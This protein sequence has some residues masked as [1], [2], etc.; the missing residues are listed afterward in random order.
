MKKGNFQAAR[1]RLF[2]HFS[3]ALP[4][5]HRRNRDRDKLEAQPRASG[6]KREIVDEVRT[7]RAV[8]KGT[9]NAP[10]NARRSRVDEQSLHGVA[11]NNGLHGE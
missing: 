10:S 9:V 2:L 1:T 11:H 5:P 4:R 6:G 7:G 3:F 8:I